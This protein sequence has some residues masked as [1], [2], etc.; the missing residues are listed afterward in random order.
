MTRPNRHDSDTILQVDWVKRPAVSSSRLNVARGPEIRKD[1]HIVLQRLRPRIAILVVMTLVTQALVWATHTHAQHVHVHA[2]IDG[3]ALHCHSADDPAAQAPCHQHDEGGD[4]QICWTLV[5]GGSAVLPTLVAVSITMR[6]RDQLL[7]LVVHR[8][9][10]ADP[11]I[12]YRSRAPPERLV[13]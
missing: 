10:T 1:W 3:S 11:I 6:V 4:C 2:G 7:G 8:R 12:G 5:S 13:R 9:P